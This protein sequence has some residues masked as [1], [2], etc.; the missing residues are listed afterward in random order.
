MSVLCGGG[1]G[2]LTACFIYES[3]FYVCVCVCGV[4]VRVCVCVSY[5]RRI[6]TAHS[7][8]Y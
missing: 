4:C 7:N 1:G 2:Q 3:V 6:A 8:N 5:Q